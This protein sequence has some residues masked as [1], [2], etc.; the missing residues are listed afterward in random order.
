MARCGQRQDHPGAR[1]FRGAGWNVIKLI[2]ARSE[3]DTVA[4]VT[5]KASRR[6]GWNACDGE[7]QTFKGQGRRLH[8][9]SISSTR[10]TERRWL[11]T[12]PTT[13]Y[14]TSNRGGHDIFKIYSAY[15]AAVPSPWSAD[16]DPRQDHQRDSAWAAGESQMNIA[17]AEEARSRLDPPVPRPLRSAG[18]RRPARR[19]AFKFPEDSPRIQIHAS[20]VAA[21]PRWLP[22]EP[23]SHRRW[24]W[25]C[26]PRRLRDAMQGIR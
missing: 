8:S 22:A 18:T 16:P 7:Y 10:R 3:W 9:A 20:S 11:R 4:S 19:A 21:G 13:R 1:V 23:S 5:R 25:P 26:R 2:W 6:D 17:P 14:G 12:G 24:P 15:N